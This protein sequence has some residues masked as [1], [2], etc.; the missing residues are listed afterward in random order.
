[1]KNINRISIFLPSLLTAWEAKGNTIDIH[2]HLQLKQLMDKLPDDIKIEEFKT[3]L[4]PIL[5]NDKE[6]QEDFYELFERLL[7]A[8][9][10]RIKEHQEH[11]PSFINENTRIVKNPF[12]NPKTANLL[13]A[14]GLKTS[15]TEKPFDNFLYF[16]NKHLARISIVSG[17]LIM[18]IIL[19][20][21][22][23]N[24]L[25]QQDNY[26]TIPHE[27]VYVEANLDAL[28]AETICISH[29][30]WSD[31][32]SVEPYAEIDATYIEI[33]DEYY[34]EPNF[35]IRYKAKSQ[36]RTS[37]YYTI[38]N[39]ND[40]CRL[41]E[42]VFRVDTFGRT[43]TRQDIS[44][45]EFVIKSENNDAINQMSNQTNS[46][47]TAF[48]SIEAT[49][50][51][52][53]STSNI[54]IGGFSD[55]TPLKGILVGSFAF[56]IMGL[57]Y[58]IRYKSKKTVI[59]NP[60]DETLNNNYLA[61]PPLQNIDFGLPFKRI[62]TEMR[63]RIDSN[64]STLDIDKTIQ[65]S[66]KNAG[67]ISFEYTTL[68][69]HQRYL[70]LID[71]NSI[72]NHQTKLYDK[73]IK[74]LQENEAPITLF[75]FDKTV[76]RF[77]NTRFRK[78]LSL[79]QLQHRYADAQL[80]IFGNGEQFSTT[81]PFEA[82]RNKVLLTP[83]SVDQW[84]STEVTLEQ[85]FSVL[86]ATTEGLN[87]LMEVI[88]T[89]EPKPFLVEYP[90][91]EP[92][93][94]KALE[95]PNDCSP[96]ELEAFFKENL[97][98]IN[99]T[100]ICWI[101]ACAFPKVLYWNWTQLVGQFLSTPNHNLLTI[102]NYL[103]LNRLQW[104]SKDYKISETNRLALLNWLETYFPELFD[105]LHQLWGEV[106]NLEENI[107]PPG[108]DEWKNHRI[109]V[110]LN[111]LPSFKS[112]KERRELE[113]ELE[114]L[115][116]TNY[117]DDALVVK[118]REE[119]K[120]PL[121][122]LLSPMFKQ[123]VQKKK[124]IFWKW[125]D[126]TWQVAAIGMVFLLS[127]LTNLSQ[128]VTTLQFDEFI[129]E[130]AFAKDSKSFVV[131]HG[132]G[133]IAICDI[134]GKFLQGSE[135][136]REDII[137]MAFSE[138]GNTILTATN[139]SEFAFWDISGTPIYQNNLDMPLANDIAFH[140]KN[141]NLIVVGQYN[142]KAVVY[143]ITNPNDKIELAHEHSV[144]TVTFSNDGNYIVTG[145]RD[146]TTKLWSITGELVQTFDGHE[147]T[148]H[149]VAISNDN[150]TIVTG[151]RDNTAKIWNK[152]GALVHNEKHSYDVFKTVFSP[153]GKTFITTTDQ[154][155]YLWDIET[156]KKIRT[157]GGH[158]YP[159]KAAAFS[160]DGKYLIVGDDYGKV[161]IWTL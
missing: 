133:K 96:D 16:T 146:Q 65:Q 63:K 144:E 23:N 127:L 42:F 103:Q 21:L 109:Q 138:D 80:L 37:A 119:K 134:N 145:S 27:V 75:H 152:D 86:P 35:C 50:D 91:E 19:L 57:T 90:V 48:L 159:I 54:R 45:D 113:E 55:F 137:G 104:F 117:L 9:K 141:Q 92:S 128:P 6:L 161:K 36:G 114:D 17:L 22:Q 40:D 160:P 123:F 106:L 116:Y 81:N 49:N 107:P 136:E 60:I 31:N 70:V 39:N 41:F 53:S 62:L 58:F 69:E 130:I 150:N 82:W 3:I 157:F 100:I 76:D 155:A 129:T 85:H 24:W 87:V 94:Y 156:K 122:T 78:G 93:K 99:D 148:I 13:D 7:P 73:F 131:A 154:K 11:I 34:T 10:E 15:E 26:N 147:H 61:V 52:E 98:G 132:N 74:T 151:S 111:L 110:I 33:E 140:P 124:A 101:A 2:Q 153:D 125:R 32:I 64:I 97:I 25:S 14:E 30:D 28:E 18:T 118:Y 105:E 51:I 67:M 59:E 142:N 79:F 121:D 83:K 89:I 126:W 44:N 102:E 8:F 1:M 77:W 139:E 72:H 158:R 71:N 20:V 29:P 120:R 143:D 88:E 46:L 12:Y 115:I 47:D 38:C 112:G 95:V 108:T 43:P 5:A 149:S 84:S 56:F 135:I 66:I 4:S 68:T